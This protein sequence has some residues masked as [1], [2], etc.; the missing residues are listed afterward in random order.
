MMGGAKCPEGACHELNFEHLV[1]QRMSVAVAGRRVK[2]K[3][4]NLPRYPQ[5]MQVVFNEYAFSVA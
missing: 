3:T 4:C 1:A 5:S 2:R